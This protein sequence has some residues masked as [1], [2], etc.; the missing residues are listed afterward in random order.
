LWP[1][2]TLTLAVLFL[3]I[4]CSVVSTAQARQ[5]DRPIVLPV[6]N[7]SDLRFIHV[8][9]VEGQPHSRVARV[10]QDDLGFLW[11]TTQDGMQR[12]D[13][14]KFR[15]FR[16]DPRNPNS[17]TGSDS[18]ALYKDRSGQLWIGTDLTLNRYDP[19][20][21]Q[22]TEYRPDPKDPA[23][24][25]GVLY[26]I[27][28]DRAGKM[29]LTT[30]HGLTQLDPT[31]GR[32]VG[33]HHDPAD[34]TSLSTN[35][36]RATFEEADG[37][38]WVGTNEGLDVLDRSTG[39]V[40]QHIPLPK[41][42][43]RPLASNPYLS[44]AFC[45]DHAGILW[46]TFSYG[47]G[48]ASVNRTANQLTF[49]S[50]DGTGKDNTLQSGARALYEDE[51]GTLWIG[52]TANGLLKLNRERTKFIR[53]RNNPT[54]PDSLSSDQINA[55]FE[56]HEGY[57]WVGTTGGW[58]NRFSRRPLP[59][60]RYRH[61]P[62][63]PN[64]LDSNYTS[65]IYEDS[66]GM[67]WVGSMKVL[68]QID[69]KTEKF[70]FLRTAGGAGNLSSTWVI[71]IT[72]DRSGYLWFGTIGGG[73]NRYDRRSGKFKAYRHNSADPHSLSHDTVLS[74]FVDHNGTLWA[75][76][77]DGLNAFDPTKQNF[78]VY[79]AKEE[80]QRY[81]TIKE[82][83]NGGLWLGTL[84]SGL[85]YLDPVTSKFTIYKHSGISGSLSNDRVNAICIDHSGN[86][87]AGTPLGLDRFDPATGTFVTFDERDGL[88]NSNVDGILEDEHGDLWLSTNNGLARFN[89]SAKTFR[90]YSV[91]DGLLGNEFYNYASAYKS[92]S[93]ELFFNNYAGVISFFA[94]RVV[95]NPYV[96]PV[97][98]TDFL[99]FS[100]PVTIGGDSPL[101]QSISLTKSITLTHTQ[102]IFS[103]E[104]AALSYANPERN[105]YRYK[106]EGLENNWNETVG[107]R[108][109]V[110]Y[111]TLAPGEYFFRVQGSNN[112]GVWN[113]AGVNLRIVILPPWWNTWS[114]RAVAAVIFFA[115]VWLAYYL[116]VR[117]IE[118]RNV[119]LTRL[120]LELHQSERAQNQ[121]N[122]ELAQ[123][124]AERT[125]AEEEIR[126]LS[127]RL[128][129]AQE[130]ERARIARELHD[131]L[132]QQVAGVSLS[133]GAIRR[134][135][136]EA[137]T[138]VVTDFE[139][140][141][142]RLTRLGEDVRNISHE[143]HPVALDYCDIA[144]AL[145]SHCK[146]FS[147]LSG[148]STSFEAEDTYDDVPAPVALC[149]YRVTQEALQNVAKHS[150]ADS[151]RVRLSRTN[152]SISLTISDTGIGF[153]VGRVASGGLGLV[154]IK[155]RVRLV[156]G[157][158]TL[159][160]EPRRGTTLMI[161][162]PLNQGENEIPERS[163]AHT[164]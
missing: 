100:K 68:T 35:L 81:R 1:K 74:L 118:R 85:H 62:G 90:N 56:D 79:R 160:S 24:F 91:S 149:I 40:T 28:E 18:L 126:A 59:F 97:V 75:G 4:C 150:R 66:Q 65:A 136:A 107:T 21:E 109:F 17:L 14:Y 84:S 121:L 113:D 141:R 22:F 50:L 123:Q 20:T 42:F 34:P 153:P 106:L 27:R 112:R 26:D 122:R 23:R 3:L 116:R 137:K 55:L 120:N 101:K 86:L 157:K 133:L 102:S 134:K 129:T 146:E 127:E 72:E 49:Y 8:T 6:I 110:T 64:S 125:A 60:R 135:L 115:L 164:A 46:V 147:S 145:R 9:S 19:A 103:L 132:N 92:K 119:E 71:S 89:P 88:P 57:I 33:Y 37:T 53:Y 45:Q 12:F 161:D 41:S 25:D 69:P 105:R 36:V 143:L 7:R 158:F 11:L 76:T 128:I 70:T 96:P 139:E 148:V 155:E 13:G 95:D 131:D 114:F 47:Y 44:M 43:V 152:G 30:D 5:D 73:L 77:E 31:T 156:K 2:P 16:H 151:A 104:F 48:L 82:D 52:T 108:R 117:T 32:T 93:G 39:K 162:I 99:L 80:L 124:V 130:E 58:V 159:Q 67:I 83:S 142:S 154:S 163:S 38:F 98:L 51:D 10:L 78:Q 15:E 29:W 140:V 144:A 94:D 138:D 63:N 111:T 54:D 87:W 61:E